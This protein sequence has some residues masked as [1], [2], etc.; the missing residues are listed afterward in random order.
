VAL[1]NKQWATVAGRERLGICLKL[2]KFIQLIR[3]YVAQK[4][5]GAIVT[6]KTTLEFGHRAGIN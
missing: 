3:S 5:P 4:E 6:N 2:L 1:A